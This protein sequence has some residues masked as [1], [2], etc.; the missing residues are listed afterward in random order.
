MIG[1]FEPVA[2]FGVVGPFEPVEL[3]NGP[4][5]LVGPFPLVG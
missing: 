1:L 3:F 5:K 2:L 4:F